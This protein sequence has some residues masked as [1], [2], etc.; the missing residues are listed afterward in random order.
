MRQALKRLYSLHLDLVHLNGIHFVS[1]LWLAIEA[2]CVFSDS[3]FALV[4]SA[5]Q[6]IPV[7]TDTQ[8]SG[9]AWS[10]YTGDLV[11]HDPQ[12]QLSR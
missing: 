12:N 5:L 7:L 11:S 8:D 1:P 6:A 9:F 10:V 3:P 2:K 4:A